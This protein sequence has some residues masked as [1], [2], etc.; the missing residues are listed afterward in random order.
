MKELWFCFTILP[1]AKLI[2]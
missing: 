1:A 2:F